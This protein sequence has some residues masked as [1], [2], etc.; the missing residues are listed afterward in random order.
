MDK[1]F[2]NKYLDEKGKQ[3]LKALKSEIN[4]IRFSWFSA[5]LNTILV[6]S[7][8]VLMIFVMVNATENADFWLS[9]CYITVVLIMHGLV[10]LSSF[11]KERNKTA[12]HAG[13]LIWHFVIGT[14]H[15]VVFFSLT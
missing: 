8:I 3:E 13:G 15:S 14:F 2:A 9:M 6:L 4:K 12:G 10:P 11:L 5:F 7:F 1:K